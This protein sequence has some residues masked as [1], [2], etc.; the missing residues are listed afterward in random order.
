MIL[1]LCDGKVECSNWVRCYVN[2]QKHN[3][4]CTLTADPY[5]ARNGF[6]A[7][8]QNHPERFGIVRDPNNGQIVYY[9]EKEQE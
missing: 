7:D 9:Y 6:C 2:C 5:H 4:A 3:I 8:P 1:Y